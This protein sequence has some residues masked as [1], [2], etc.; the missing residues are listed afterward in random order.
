MQRPIPQPLA[1]A[2]DARDARPDRAHGK[3]PCA[4]WRDRRADHTDLRYGLGCGRGC[5]D[6]SGHH[7]T[8]RGATPT[9]AERVLVDGPDYLAQVVN[10]GTGGQLGVDDPER[11]QGVR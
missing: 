5:R 3:A 1:D 10:L 7:K 4:V 9:W 6:V 8:L 11:S 2:Y